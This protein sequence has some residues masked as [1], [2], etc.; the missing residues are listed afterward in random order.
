MREQ[1]IVHAGD[2]RF[3]ING[4]APGPKAWFDL[5]R[6]DGNRFEFGVR[7]FRQIDDAFVPPLWVEERGRPRIVC[8]TGGVFGN[9]RIRRS[10]RAGREE[11]ATRYGAK[12]VQH[13]GSSRS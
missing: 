10:G 1:L 7:R 9:H 12:L 11:P 3:D 13:C 8:G 5:N 4:A 2:A 6:M